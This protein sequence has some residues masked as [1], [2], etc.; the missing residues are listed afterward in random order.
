M[1]CPFLPSRVE[2]VAI[3]SYIVSMRQRVGHDLLLLPSVA[4][5]PVDD[6]GRVLLVRQIDTGNWATIGGMVEVDESPEEAGVREAQEEAGVVVE[7]VRL[8]SA[9]GGPEFRGKYPNGDEVA[10]VSC[11]YAARVISGKPT[12]DG[13]ETS[14]VGWFE[15]DI[16]PSLTLNALNRRLLSVTLPLL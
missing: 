2:Q 5:L 12:H 13:D 10:Y 7:L 11:V 16:I 3:S 9:L 8:V 4:V 1:P 14:E 15:K 6:L